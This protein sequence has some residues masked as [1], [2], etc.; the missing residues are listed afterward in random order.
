MNLNKLKT[1][2]RKISEKIVLKPFDLKDKSRVAALDISFEGDEGYG[3]CVVLNQNMEVIEI[4]TMKKNISFPYI[5]GFL[6]FRE[7]PVIIKLYEKIKKEPDLILIDG[8]G[9]IHPR[10]CGVA[11]HFGVSVKKPTIGVAKSLLCG[12][13]REPQ[14]IKFSTSYVYDDNGVIIGA[15]M[16]TKENAKA[17]FISPGNMIDIDSS[18][19]TIK[20]FISKYRIPDP[21]RIAHLESNRLRKTFA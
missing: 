12:K 18:I 21:I 2:Q 3:V 5:P 7:M 8:N 11:V 1:I 15:A 17:I 20:K 14:N 9:T 4:Y 13:Y 19:K 10:K 6:A 16:R